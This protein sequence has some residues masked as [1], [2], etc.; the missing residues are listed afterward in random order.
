VERRS[1]GDQLRACSDEPYIDNR[2]I[3][4]FRTGKGYCYLAS[5]DF[6]ESAPS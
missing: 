3:L 5:Y 1:F 2:D 6:Q 4:H